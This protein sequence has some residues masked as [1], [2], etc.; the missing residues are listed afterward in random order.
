MINDTIDIL[1]VKIINIGI[2]FKSGFGSNEKGNTQRILQV[3]KIYNILNPDYKLYLLVRQN[4]NNNYL[5]KIENSGVWNVIKGNETYNFLSEISGCNATSFIKNEID[6]P[7]D[8]DKDV[9]D[10]IGL[11]IDNRERYLEWIS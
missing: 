6:F 5:T 1:D 3:G 9:Y 11:S 2:D 7:S 4:E 8:I 10:D